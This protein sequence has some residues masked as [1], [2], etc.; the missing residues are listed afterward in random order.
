MTE[1]SRTGVSLEQDLLDKFDGLISRRGYKNRSEALR[2]LIRE[3]LLSEAVDA[4]HPVVGTLTLIY[5]HHLPN[6]SQKLTE[7]QHMA[8]NMVLATTHVHLDEIYCLE[9]IIMKGRS[10][11]MRA[12]ADGMLSLR[13]VKHGKLVLTGT[14]N[15]GTGMKHS[16]KGH[17]HGLGAHQH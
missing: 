7:T 11:E 17:R 5:D 2:D 12:M 9:V 16:A 8:H 10:K 3:A 6:L 15:D 14:G 13:G 4:N 1:L